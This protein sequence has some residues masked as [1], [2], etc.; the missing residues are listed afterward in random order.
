MAV[1]PTA[2]SLPCTPPDHVES[3]IFFN[4]AGSAAG[5]N[6]P[7]C[8]YRQPDLIGA[9]LSSEAGN[10]GG[11]DHIGQDGGLQPCRIGIDQIKN[12]I[13]R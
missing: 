7:V 3:E 12:G 5:K 2:C 10:D 6:Q 11:M 13:F 4:A 8:L 9:H 1:F